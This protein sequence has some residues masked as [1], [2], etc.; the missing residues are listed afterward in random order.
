MKFLLIAIVLLFGADSLFANSAPVVSNV[1]VSQRTDGSKLVDIRYN[2]YDADGDKCTVSVQVSS[3]SGST[4][5]VSAVSF[6]PVSAIGSDISAGTGKH[7]IWDCR[8]DLPGVFDSDYC[9]K[10]TADDG[11]EI[12]RDDFRGSLTWTSSDSTVYLKVVGIA[13]YDRLLHLL[14]FQ[15]GS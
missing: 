12:F 9:V 5:T 8:A 3:D 11:Q 4:W 2:L 7:I 6:D 13:A 10:V 15:R 14:A 1:T